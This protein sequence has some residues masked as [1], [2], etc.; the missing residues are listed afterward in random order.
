MRSK[1]FVC[2]N[3]KSNTVGRS[4]VSI[5]TVKTFAKEWTLFIFYNDSINYNKNKF[6]KCHIFIMLE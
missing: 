3:K 2:V 6:R 5:I 4:E 1:Y